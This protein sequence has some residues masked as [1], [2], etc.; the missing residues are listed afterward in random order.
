MYFSDFTN[1]PVGHLTLSFGEYNF[2]PLYV[3][4]IAHLPPE[5][6]RQYLITPL[7]CL[8]LLPLSPLFPCILSS[9]QFIFHTF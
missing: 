4:M 3:Y 9:R 7:S 8:L 5:L 2:V 6:Q 1:F